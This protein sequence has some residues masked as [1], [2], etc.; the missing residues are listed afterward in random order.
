MVYQRACAACHSLTPGRKL[1][2]PSLA[3]VW[4]RPIGKAQGYP[5]SP[6]LA[7]ATGAWDA[8]RL[9]TWLD[10]PR[11]AY[12]GTKMINRL[13]APTDRAAVI[14]YLKTRPVK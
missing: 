11:L 8:R 10:N 3:S 14:A 5:F 1:N 4:G 2:G 12:P 9:D 7:K 6:A 13:L